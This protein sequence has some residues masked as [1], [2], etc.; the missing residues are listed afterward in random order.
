MVSRN[1]HFHGLLRKKYKVYNYWYIVPLL[2]TMIL[3]LNS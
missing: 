2:A 3:T 1:C